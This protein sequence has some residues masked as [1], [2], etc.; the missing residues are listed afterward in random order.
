MEKFLLTQPGDIHNS[1]PRF[2]L[3]IQQVEAIQFLEV[4]RNW[5]RK[6]EMKINFNFWAFIRKIYTETF[7]SF[8]T[9][10]GF[11]IR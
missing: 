6:C 5:T 9:R 2:Y 11:I 8:L 7:S 3:A 10:L 1:I 4:E